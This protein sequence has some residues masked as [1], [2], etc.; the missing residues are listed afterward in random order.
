MNFAPFAKG[1]LAKP[2][3]K[4]LRQVNAGVNYA[5]PPFSASRP[6]WWAARAGRGSGALGQ[7]YRDQAPPLRSLTIQKVSAPPSFSHSR[8]LRGLCEFCQVLR[9]SVR[10]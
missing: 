2:L 5:G 7:S 10:T 4:G 6:R 3:V 1:R 8:S 9:S